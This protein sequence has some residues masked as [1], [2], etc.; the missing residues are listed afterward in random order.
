MRLNDLLLTG[1]RQ[2][3][4]FFERNGLGLEKSKKE[5]LQEVKKEISE[6]CI[7]FQ[8]NLNEDTTALLFTK[9]ELEGMSEDFL[10]SLTKEGDKYRVTLQ[11]PHLFPV[12]V[13]YWSS[14]SSL[15]GLSFT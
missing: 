4:E 10:N 14:L 7:K 2:V 3:L 11:Y 5:R 1:S 9:E 13:S 6:L 12:Y 8:Q 15:S